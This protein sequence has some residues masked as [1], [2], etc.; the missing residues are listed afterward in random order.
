MKNSTLRHAKKEVGRLKSK[1]LQ[2]LL[3]IH[4]R[5]YMNKE[6]LFQDRSVKWKCLESVNARLDFRK[7]KKNK[8][9]LR[10]SQNFDDDRDMWSPRF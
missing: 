8:F 7:T 10:P 6:N 2:L 1:F 5:N 4:T 9:I 3:K